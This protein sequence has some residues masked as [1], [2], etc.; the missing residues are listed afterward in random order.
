MLTEVFAAFEEYCDPNI[1]I[2]LVNRDGVPIA[3]GNMHQSQLWAYS[4]ASVI[5]FQMDKWNNH[6]IIKIDA[7]P[8]LI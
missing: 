6:A 4:Y 1:R 2:T 8:F 7:D 5:E 3:G